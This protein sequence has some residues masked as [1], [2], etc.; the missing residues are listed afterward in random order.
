[1][2]VT[3]DVRELCWRSETQLAALGRRLQAALTAWAEAWGLSTSDLRCRNAWE[4]R[5]AAS[6]LALAVDSAGAA[7]VWWNGEAVGLGQA[8]FGGQQRGTVA[9]Q[10]GANAP[11][12]EG[13]A[14]DALEALRAAINGAMGW[15][16][17]GFGDVSAAPPAADAKAWSGAVSIEC[18]IQGVQMLDLKLHL[19]QDA[20]PRASQQGKPGPQGGL[21]SLA[22]QLADQPVAVRACMAD[23]TM[24]LGEL[25]GLQLGDV[26]VTP[27]RLDAPLAI[28]AGQGGDGASPLFSGWLAQ[29]SGHMAVSLAP[30]TERAERQ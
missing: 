17:A 25:M 5:T 22:A 13:V 1:V 14:S 16:G 8:I 3:A 18:R 24:S 6:W 11:V 28:E 7:N 4:A 29:R 21:N 19:R 9:P 15:H 10:G 26:L 23:V 2:S 20:W 12:A 27:Q 30:A